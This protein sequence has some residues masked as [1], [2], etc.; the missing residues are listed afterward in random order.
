MAV[1]GSIV[2][3]TSRVRPFLKYSVAWTSDGAGA[4]TENAVTLPAGWI[5]QVICTPGATTPSDD[6]DVTLTAATGEGD[7]L[8]GGGANMS[9][10]LSNHI[11]ADVANL[12]IAIAGGS[13]WPTVAAAGAAKTGTIDI[14]MT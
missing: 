9:N 11:G 13:Y 6:Y 14:Y 1:A 4:V 7:L 5:H 2:V 3:T 8:G 10:S 12:P